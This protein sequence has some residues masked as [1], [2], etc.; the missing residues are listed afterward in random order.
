MTKNARP[1]YAEPEEPL[2]KLFRMG[3]DPDLHK[4]LYLEPVP[5]TELGDSQ[6]EEVVDFYS[7]RWEH[8]LVPEY[9]AGLLEA[10]VKTPGLPVRDAIHT[11]VWHQLHVSGERFPEGQMVLVK[12]GRPAIL[13][14]SQ[15]WHVPEVSVMTSYFEIYP[16]T[17]Y[18]VSGNGCGYPWIPVQVDGK[19]KRFKDYGEALSRVDDVVISSYALTGNPG[20]RVKG[21]SRAAVYERAVFAVNMGIKHCDTC[22]PL[23]NYSRWAEEKRR[24]NPGFECTPEKFIEESV[25]IPINEGTKPKYYTAIGMHMSYGAWSMKILPGAREHDSDSDGHCGFCRYF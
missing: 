23:N 1:D 11:C 8:V 20:F 7:D 18:L 3:I 24:E 19:P 21:A 9:R 16:C 10:Q 13:T 6:K 22:S 5:F 4:K 12:D 25:V 2:K 17:W 15:P 14:R